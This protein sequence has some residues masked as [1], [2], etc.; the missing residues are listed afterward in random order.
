M[1]VYKG[2]VRLFACAA[3]IVALGLAGCGSDTAVELV[4]GGPP[5][6]GPGGAVSVD[7]FASFQ[8]DVDEHWEGSAAMAAGEFLRLDERT[9]TTTTIEGTAS[10]EG[11][12]PQTVIV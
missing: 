12:G 1:G 2:D 9:A 5:E 3:S 10:A 6:P 4:W 8:R 7:G 11:T